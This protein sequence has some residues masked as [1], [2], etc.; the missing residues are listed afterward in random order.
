MLRTM[1]ARELLLAYRRGTDLIMP[2]AFFLIVTCMLALAAGPQSLRMIGPG[3]VWVGAALSLMLSLPTMFATDFEEGTLDQMNL[4]GQPMIVFVGAK[5]IG[6]WLTYGLPLVL[7][8]PVI[9]LQFDLSG[10]AILALTASLLLG[11]PVFSLLGAIV[12]ALTVGLRGCA[13]LLPLLVLPLTVPVLIFGSGAV[14]AVADLQDPSA[15]FSLLGAM[16]LLALVAAP[17]A[18]KG[19]L[20]LLN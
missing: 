14:E 18:A 12:A 20:R 6:H 11:T 3:V 9:A 10:Q 1:I 8:A 17:L 15:N 5:I 7:A 16:L 4:S 19:A 2:P 13:V